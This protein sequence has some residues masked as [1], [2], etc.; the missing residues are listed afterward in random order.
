VLYTSFRW[1]PGPVLVSM[2]IFAGCDGGITAES[3]CARYAAGTCKFTLSCSSFSAAQYGSEAN[4]R[5]FFEDLCQHVASVEGAAPPDQFA[6]C[7][8]GWAAQTCDAGFSTPDACNIQGTLEGGAPCSSSLQCKSLQC[9][10]GTSECGT[11]T[12]PIAEG[13]ACDPMVFASCGVFLGCSASTSTCVRRG[14]VGEACTE[15]TCNLLLLCTD[16]T[17]TALGGEGAPCDQ[18]Q[19]CDLRLGLTCNMVT[20][21]CEEYVAAALGEFCGTDQTTGKSSSCMYDSRCEGSV[22]VALKGEGD[23]CETAG[24]C[25]LFFD[26][27]DGTCA[28]EPI[29]ECPAPM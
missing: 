19:G 13:D 11:C 9:D 2:A 10:N 16:G 8:D 7:G 29:P 14:E 3:G 20:G 6:A 28:R 24:E 27:L 15:G 5:E 25:G 26:C 18:G 12:T 21:L 23:P 4:C 22:C 17:C 1:A